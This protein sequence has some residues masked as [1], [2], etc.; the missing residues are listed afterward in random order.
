[1][2]SLTTSSLPKW[3]QGLLYLAVLF[4]RMFPV[5]L[6]TPV[7][8]THY[9]ITFSTSVLS[10][11]VFHMRLLIIVVRFVPSHIWPWL[12]AGCIA[13]PPARFASTSALICIGPTLT[14]LA[15]FSLLHI[16]ASVLPST[17]TAWVRPEVAW[18]QLKNSKQAL[19]CRIGKNLRIIITRLFGFVQSLPHSKWNRPTPLAAVERILD[20]CDASQLTAAFAV[21]AAIKFG[22]HL[23]PSKC[24]LICCII[25]FV[26][27]PSSLANSVTLAAAAIVLPSFPSASVDP[28]SPARR[29]APPN[30]ADQHADTSPTYAPTNARPYVAELSQ[31]DPGLLVCEHCHSATRDGRGCGF[32]S[33]RKPHRRSQNPLCQ[34]SRTTRRHVHTRPFCSQ[35]T[36]S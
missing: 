23:K 15:A 34:H 35:Y 2:S 5:V 12:S 6:L 30:V 1:M 8:L 21:L 36:T 10:T 32:P 17:I 26:L 13:E 14:R 3:I 20:T 7:W 33:G 18:G 16:A 29:W 11:S 9:T 28:H 24:R 27:F 19:D 25:T 4:V 22:F 31:D